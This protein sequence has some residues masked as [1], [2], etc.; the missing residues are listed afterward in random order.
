VSNFYFAQLEEIERFGLTTLYVD[1]KN[2]ED[3]TINGETGVLA[4]AISQ[5]YYRYLRPLYR[6]NLDFCPFLCEDCISFS[7]NIN[8]N[9]TSL[10]LPLRRR[11]PSLYT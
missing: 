5:Q 4:Q 11:P 9:I 1:F 10:R 3:F 6:A 2:L 7:G 8:P